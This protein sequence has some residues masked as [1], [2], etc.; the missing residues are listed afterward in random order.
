MKPRIGIASSMAERSGCAIAQ[1]LGAISPTTRCRNV[2]MSNASTKP[3]TSANHDGAPNP[4]I[5]GVIA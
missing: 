4:P 2:T 3:P 5:Q 1:D